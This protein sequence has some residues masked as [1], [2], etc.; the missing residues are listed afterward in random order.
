MVVPSKTV[1]TTVFK[2]LIL[3]C[4]NTANAIIRALGV[5]PK[6]ELSGRGPPRSSA[7]WF[8]A[9]PPSGLDADHATLLD[10]TLRFSDHSAADVMTPRVRMAKVAAAATAADVIDLSQRTGFSRFP[11]IGQDADDIL[12]V[13]HVKPGLR[14]RRRHP[15]AG[16][17]RGFDGRPDPGA[18]V[19]QG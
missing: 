5:E 14:P 16:S 7:S 9:R 3:L 13:V 19:H 11:V 15:A 12:G 18:G 10:R 1:F 2:P 8:D 6:E 17:R 4:N